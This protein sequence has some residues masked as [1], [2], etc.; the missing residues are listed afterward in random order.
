MMNKS[1]HNHSL[2]PQVVCL[3]FF[4]LEPKYASFQKQPHNQRRNTDA[5][6]KT[7]PHLK[8]TQIGVSLALTCLQ[9]D[10]SACFPHF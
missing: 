3:C 8:G 4:T 10:C 9:S 5:A 7:R 1:P 6:K 2:V